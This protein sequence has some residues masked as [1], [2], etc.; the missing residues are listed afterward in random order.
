[1]GK[2]GPRLLAL[3]AGVK[4]SDYEF[5]APSK[6]KTRQA[7]KKKVKTPPPAPLTPEQALL[8]RREKRR[9]ERQGKR[10]KNYI[11]KLARMV[12]YDL[13]ELRATAFEENEKA[14]R[15][16]QAAAARAYAKKLGA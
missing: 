12:A 1:M 14:F 4:W 6:K 10:I 3:P 2:Q 16:Q 11:K 15:E 8:K 13:L 7:P 5:Q 9:R